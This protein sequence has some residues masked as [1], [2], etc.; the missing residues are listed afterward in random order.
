MQDDV[1]VATYANIDAL[2]EAIGL[3]QQRL[4]KKVCGDLLISTENITLIIRMTY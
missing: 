2:V 4:Q 3:N 1:V